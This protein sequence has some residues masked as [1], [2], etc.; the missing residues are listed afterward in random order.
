MKNRKQNKSN[1]HENQNH[2]WSTRY[3]TFYYFLFFSFLNCYNFI[4]ENVIELKDA[5]KI[6][7]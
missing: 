5:K 3:K 4:L 2:I 6:I 7:I 1:N